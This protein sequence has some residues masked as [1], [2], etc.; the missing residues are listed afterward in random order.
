MCQSQDNTT[1]INTFFIK[2]SLYSKVIDFG[3]N[4]NAGI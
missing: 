3:E 4:N 1:K 2:P